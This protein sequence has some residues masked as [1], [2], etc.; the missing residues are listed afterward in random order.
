MHMC[1][2]IHVRDVGVLVMRTGFASTTGIK[3]HMDA[4]RDDTYTLNV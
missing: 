4:V 1:P 3:F 2:S